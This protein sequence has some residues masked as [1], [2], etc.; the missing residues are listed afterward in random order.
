M[1][2]DLTAWIRRLGSDGPDL[3]ADFLTADFGRNP[4]DKSIPVR[5]TGSQQADNALRGKSDASY[6]VLLVMQALAIWVSL[7]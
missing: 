7:L 5:Y 6:S 4:I 2:L 3:T 1:P